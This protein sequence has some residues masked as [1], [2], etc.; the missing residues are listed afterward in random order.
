MGCRYVGAAVDTCIG[1]DACLAKVCS[2]LP[3]RHVQNQKTK[4]PEAN[5]R[6]RDTVWQGIR[7]RRV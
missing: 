4:A 3:P 7:P 1:S 2:V 6:D 5:L